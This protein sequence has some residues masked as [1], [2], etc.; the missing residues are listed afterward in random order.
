MTLVANTTTQGN[1][2]VPTPAA[3]VIPLRIALPRGAS[4]GATVRTEVETGGARVAFRRNIGLSSS[5]NGAAAVNPYDETPYG[6]KDYTDAGHDLPEVTFEADGA[7]VAVQ[8]IA[9]AG[10]AVT[11]SATVNVSGAT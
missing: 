1:H 8:V 9:P 11:V 3:P 4:G 7:E 6:A 10:S 2:I 5:T